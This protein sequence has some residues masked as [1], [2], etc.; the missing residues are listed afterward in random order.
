M[1]LC[2]TFTKGNLVIPLSYPEDRT[3]HRAM[4]DLDIKDTDTFAMVPVNLPIP[5]EEGWCLQLAGAPQID[6][7]GRYFFI[8][9]KVRVLDGKR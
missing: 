9:E 7:T 3:W 2:G 4:F 8:A 5:V 1:K 6:K